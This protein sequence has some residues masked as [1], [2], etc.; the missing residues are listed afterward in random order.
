MTIA[1][2]AVISRTA[3]GLAIGNKVV[4]ST[5]GALPTGITA[6]TDYYVITAGF[7]ANAF[8]VSA[9]PG[10]SAVDTSGT[11]SGSHTFTASTYDNGVIWTEVSGLNTYNGDGGGTAWGAPAARVSTVSVAGWNVAGDQ[12]LVASNH[13]ETWTA[14]LNSTYLGTPAAPVKILSVD[15]TVV[16]STNLTTLKAGASVLTTAGASGT[17][18][19]IFGGSANSTGGLYMYGVTIAVG[20]ATASAAI[21]LGQAGAQSEFVIESCNFIINGSGTSG[22]FVIGPS[23]SSS[24]VGQMIRLKN[25]TLKFANAGHSIK[26]GSGYVN[27]D[28]L[29]LTSDSTAP[30]TLFSSIGAGSHSIARMSGCDFS[31]VAGYLFDMTAAS[32]CEWDIY[33]S[34]SKLANAVTMKTGTIPKRG[35]RINLHNCDSTNTNYREYHAS[36]AGEIQQEA[37]TVRTGGAT[38]GTTP[39]SWKMES[40]ANNRIEMPLVSD[41]IPIWNESTGSALT[42]TVEI[43]GESSLTNAD[44]SLE[45]QYL[46]NASYPISSFA[47]NAPANILTAGTTLPTSSV[48]WGG[49]PTYKQYMQTSFTPQMKGYIMARV[50][51]AKASVISFVD[52]KITVS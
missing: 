10:G 16:P 24:G 1:S 33:V 6:G 51:L 4:F 40:S 9:T 37:T 7:G 22:R 12:I 29:S 52:T 19:A 18:G 2:P 21:I 42:A 41:W 8:Q 35:I 50:I 46:G 11:Q 30:T 44:I 13:A 20:N 28:G 43:A 5:T 34:S 32:T 15:E 23:G 49:S 27:I 25:C 31:K 17:S 48:S 26:L 3:H 38:N 14:A 47:S 45:I 39:I 36:Y